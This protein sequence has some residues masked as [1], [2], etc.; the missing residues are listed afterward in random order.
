M[1][2][3]RSPRDVC[4]TT[5]GTRGLI[6]GQSIYGPG[7]QSLSGRLALGLFA[8]FGV[9]LGLAL[10]RR[11][12]RL[13][14]LG[15]RDRDRLG[16]VGDQLGGLSQAHLFAQHPVAARL[17]QLRQH[18][19]RLLLAVAGPERLDQVL[20][21]RLDALGLGDGGER[22]LAP[23]ASSRRTPRPRRSSRGGPC[24]ASARTSAGRCRGPEGSARSAPKARALGRGR[25]RAGKSIVAF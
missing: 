25:G 24:P 7:V 4:S 14:R 11:P 20:V 2:K 12:D 9:A 8:A 6:G 23:Q 5:I 21:G 3:A 13:A 19:L 17:A 10:L 15:L 1:S 22:R 16:G 18:L